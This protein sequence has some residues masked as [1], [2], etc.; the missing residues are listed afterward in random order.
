[1]ASELDRADYSLNKYT[2]LSE[3]LLLAMHSLRERFRR[4][5]LSVN[6]ADKRRRSLY[7]LREH[8]RLQQFI[9]KSGALNPSSQTLS[10][11][12]FAVNKQIQ[13]Y[14]LENESVPIVTLEDRFAWTKRLQQALRL[15]DISGMNSNIP[16]TDAGGGSLTALVSLKQKPQKGEVGPQTDVEAEPGQQSDARGTVGSDADTTTMLAKYSEIRNVCREFLD[17]VRQDAMLLVSEHKQPPH[18]K[19]VPVHAEHAVHGRAKECGRGMNGSGNRYTYF[20]HN[21]EYVVVEDYDGV[22]NGSDEYASKAAGNERRCSLEYFKSYIPGLNIPLTATVDFFGFR[23]LAVAKQ[24]IETIQFSEDGEIRKIG[25]ECVHG[26]IRKGDN[27]INKG[28]AAQRLLK[29]FAM[30]MNLAE[31]SVK[32]FHDILP[33]MTW[34]SADLKV[35]KGFNDEF[36]CTN[37]YRSLPAEMAEETPHLGHVPR[38]QSVF[39]RQLRPEFI[40]NYEGPA[41]SPDAVSTIVTDAVDRYEQYDNSL[42]STKRLMNVLVPGLL[43][44]LV[45]REYTIPVSEGLGL[46]LAAEFHCRGVNIRHMGHMRALLWRDLPGTIN[47]YFHENFVRTSKDHRLEVRVGDTLLVDG[48]TY[49]IQESIPD[50]GK[51]NT[52]GVFEKPNLLTAKT[53][54]INK[55]C[56]SESRNKLLARIGACVSD[57]NNDILR[58][59]FLAEMVAR[60]IKSLIRLQLRTYC[61]REKCVT[62]P[63]KTCLLAEYFNVV[64]G[65]SQQANKVLMESVYEVVREKYGPYAILPSEQRN[66]QHELSPCTLYVIK[67]LQSMLGVRLSLSC[68]S[69]FHERPHGF[70]FNAIDFVEINPVVRH[71]IPLL[72]FSEAVL[73]SIQAQAAEKEIYLEQVMKD[74]PVVFFKLSE[75]SG[76]RVAENVSSVLGSKAV[77][78][79]DRNLVDG[80][81]SHY[82]ELEQEGPVP[83][84]PFI[85]S[86]GFKLET[87]AWCETK[88]HPSAVPIRWLQHFSVEAF[89]R[90]VGG[91]N[92]TRTALMSGRYAIVASRDNYWT[93]VLMQEMLEVNLRLLPVEYGVWANV[94]ATFDGTTLRCYFNSLLVALIEVEPVMNAKMQQ[95]EGEVNEK[96]AKLQQ[97]ESEERAHLKVATQKEAEIFFASKQ[98]ASVIKKAAQ[99]ILESQQYNISN[100]NLDTREGDEMEIA[101]ASGRPGS[102]S[103]GNRSVSPSRDTKDTS[104]KPGKDASNMKQRKQEALRQAKQKY[105]T[106]L[107]VKNVRE[108]AVR[109]KQLEAEV[110]DFRVKCTENGHLRSRKGIRIGAALG[111]SS[112]KDGK[113]F[114]I[115]NVSCVS[116]YYQALTSDRIRAH[117]LS[118]V[119]DK[120]K[121]AQRLYAETSFKYEEAITFAPDD[122]LVLKG[123][124]KALCQYVT[125]EL[126]SSRAAANFKSSTNTSSQVSTKAISSG[127]LKI[128]EAINHF[129]IRHIP[130]GIAEILMAMP[131]DIEFADIVCCG[132][133][134]ILGLD[135]LFFA[136]N[137]PSMSRKDLIYLPQIYGLESINNPIEMLNTC[138]NMYREVVRDVDIRYAYGEVDLGWIADLVS[139]ELVICIVKYATESGN[140]R[141]LRVGD[142]FHKAGRETI[143]ITDDDVEVSA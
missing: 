76:A 58:S 136:H 37:F 98:G 50:G 138:A 129:K 1:L 86:V 44:T 90:C 109:Y 23:V 134:T 39:W 13:L 34:A 118:V 130:E 42:M 133:D 24:P 84:D 47:F 101:A 53:I 12:E 95:F 29:M 27:F 38:D 35:F 121:Q 4:A 73:M 61:S 33:S 120:T 114:F 56:T 93:F 125:V 14:R 92:S 70:L 94:I 26:V 31:H 40:K 60:G 10:E 25:E 106:D 43:S 9:Q 81:Y 88:F 67:R 54:P 32:G 78:L 77:N 72:A 15:S 51:K 21:I 3:D 59:L 6:E 85:R 122:P 100:S 69:E 111:S 83:S 7:L 57:K 80:V 117:Y 28:K 62:M 123:Y 91:H 108:V 22:F 52:D 110:E 65:A 19:T 115:G 30:K 63:F 97:E 105:V 17:I 68:V 119:G 45:N 142:M 18:R 116:V 140:L 139:P 41:L 112:L 131:R 8:L 46:D 5:Q 36:Y 137:H 141:L 66:L 127:K 126:T 16:S 124:A 89:V 132:F 104:S 87:K 79:A 82:C 103:Q 107:Y 48:K 64:S 135:K 49:L 143:S 96:K 71:N 11:R 75:R 74:S 2:V 128:L 55:R 20:L 99:D 102:Q 113:S